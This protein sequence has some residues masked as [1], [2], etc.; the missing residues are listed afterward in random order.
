MNSIAYFDANR[1]QNNAY[2]NGALPNYPFRIPK[3]LLAHLGNQT[4]Q[5]SQNSNPSAISLQQAVMLQ[6]Q[7]SN[8]IFPGK[9][10]AQ[11]ANSTSADCEDMHLGTSSTTIKTETGAH[12][13]SKSEPINPNIQVQIAESN[14]SF[15]MNGPYNPLLYP[16]AAFTVQQHRQLM[17]IHLQMQYQLQYQQQLQQQQHLYLQQQLQQQQKQQEIARQQQEQSH[18]IETLQSKDEL[19]V[20][21]ALLSFSSATHDRNA[22]QS[23]RAD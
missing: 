17:Q 7:M 2:A 3:S 11:Q 9:Q 8:M 23:Q 12:T 22:T 1:N 4:L 13:A 19:D 14:P 18:R 6:M 10:S 16:N 15:A 5:N 20:V 21:N